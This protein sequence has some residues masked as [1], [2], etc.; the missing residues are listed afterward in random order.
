MKTNQPTLKQQSSVASPTCDVPARECCVL[1][2]G[3][4]R[5]EPHRNRRVAAAEALEKKRTKRR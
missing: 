2:A 4:P 3:G 5:N 1:A